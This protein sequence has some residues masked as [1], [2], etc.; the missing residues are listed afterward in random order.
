MQRRKSRMLITLVFY[1]RVFALS[2]FIMIWMAD[3]LT[4]AVTSVFLTIIFMIP[5]Y[6]I[7]TLGTDR[8]HGRDPAYR[9]YRES[10]GSPFWDN[11]L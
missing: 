3:L 4:I 7:V 9:S 1:L 8:I 11:L 2:F 10:G 5:A 6:L